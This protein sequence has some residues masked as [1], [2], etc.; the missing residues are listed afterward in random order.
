MLDADTNPAIQSSDGVI[1]MAVRSA[2]HSV[3]CT[4]ECYIWFWAIIV[5]TTAVSTEASTST[6][7]PSSAAAVEFTVVFVIVTSSKGFNEE[8]NDDERE[9]NLHGDVCLC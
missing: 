7:T 5:V 8:G 6:S 2:S 9:G 4:A 3:S 1:T